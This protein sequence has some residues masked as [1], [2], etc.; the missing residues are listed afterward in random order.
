MKILNYQNIFK[1]IVL[2]YILKC[3]KSAAMSSFTMIKTLLGL[4]E[5]SDKK[6]NIEKDVEDILE[7]VQ[8]RMSRPN[9]STLKKYLKEQK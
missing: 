8:E 6:V 7:E 9:L 1:Q 2:E 3:E 5:K 4:F